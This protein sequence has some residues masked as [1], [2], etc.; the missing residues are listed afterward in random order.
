MVYKNRSSFSVTFGVLCNKAATEECSRNFLFGGFESRCSFF[1]FDPVASSKLAC[2][3]VESDSSS[4]IADFSSSSCDTQQFFGSRNG[5]ADFLRMKL[6]VL[7]EVDDTSMCPSL[8]DCL[9][10]NVHISLSGF[11]SGEK[12][13]RVS[14]H[15]HSC[16]SDAYGQLSTSIQA[17]DQGN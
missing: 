7:G 9:P 13:I 15:Q 11:D 16:S 12:G 10:V 5:L 8:G 17:N 3:D 14:L 6:F 2:N 1:S 4:M